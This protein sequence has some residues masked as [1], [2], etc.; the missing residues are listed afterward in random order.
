MIFTC[1]IL[2]QNVL[3][4]A[5]HFPDDSDHSD[6]VHYHTHTEYYHLWKTLYV[7][8]IWDSVDAMD[9]KNATSISEIGWI[10]TYPYGMYE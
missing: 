1:F 5:R 9:K 6:Y 8:S 2:D 3:I 10:F 4:N 7:M